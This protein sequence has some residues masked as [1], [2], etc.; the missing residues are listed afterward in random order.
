MS[1]I[2]QF[3]KALADWLTMTILPNIPE[4]ALVV[5]GTVRGFAEIIRF[6]PDMVHTAILDRMPSAK[7]LIND[8]IVDTDALAVMIPAFMQ[9]VKELDLNTLLPGITY[10][11]SEQE[12]Q[13]LCNMIARGKESPVADGSAGIVMG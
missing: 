1:T 6:R 9:E 2:K 11:A 7:A 4:T 5:R 3:A 13:V 12:V 8:G 10:K